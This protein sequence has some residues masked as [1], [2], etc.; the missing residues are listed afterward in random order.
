MSG[1]K[2]GDGAVIGAHAV[3]AKDVSP[4]CIVVGNPARVVKK[5]FNDE[6]IAFLTQLKWWDKTPEQINKM[7]PFLTSSNI[8][9]LRNLALT[10]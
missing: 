8:D 10:I 6:D 9:G 4:Y 3:V 2:I 5:R 1:V 7:L